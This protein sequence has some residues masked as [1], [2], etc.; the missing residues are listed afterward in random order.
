MCE[1]LRHGRAAGRRDSIVV[2]AEGATDRAGNRIGGDYIRQI[3]EER[4]GED[5]RVTILWPCPARRYA[6]RL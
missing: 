6:Q 3:L 1:L 5:T 2:V 4:L